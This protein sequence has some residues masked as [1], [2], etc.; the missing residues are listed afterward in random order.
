M[1]ESRSGFHSSSQVLLL[2]FFW[3]CLAAQISIKTANYIRR[4]HRLLWCFFHLFPWHPTYFRGG[5]YIL[6]SPNKALMSQWSL[7]KG[8]CSVLVIL[9]ITPIFALWWIHL[10]VTFPFWG[11]V[12]CRQ[13]RLSKIHP[14]KTFG[15]IKIISDLICVYWFIL[16]GLCIPNLTET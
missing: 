12:Y 4:R 2:Q 14:A 7:A 9:N 16:N 13:I 15:T 1:Q 3:L 8:C 10:F 11:V 6:E 5:C